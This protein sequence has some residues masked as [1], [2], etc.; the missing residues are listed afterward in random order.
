MRLFVL[1]D[2]QQAASKVADALKP[3]LAPHGQDI[4]TILPQEDWWEAGALPSRRGCRSQERWRRPRQNRCH[5]L[6][7]RH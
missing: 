3:L 5:P 7:R 2:N 1:D 4:E 6:I